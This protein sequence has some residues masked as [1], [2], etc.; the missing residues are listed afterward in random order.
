[1]GGSKTRPVYLLLDSNESF[2]EGIFVLFFGG[3]VLFYALFIFYP[4]PGL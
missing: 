2:I 3:V 1:V 4:R